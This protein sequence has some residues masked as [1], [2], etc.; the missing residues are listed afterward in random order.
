M[1]REARG[2]LFATAEFTAMLAMLQRVSDDSF[3]MAPLIASL[4]RA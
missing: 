4:I 3:L 2:A 1:L